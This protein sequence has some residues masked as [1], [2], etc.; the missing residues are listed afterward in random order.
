MPT[1]FR[2][3]TLGALARLFGLD[4]VQPGTH[5]L[6][7]L[8]QRRWRA[9]LSAASAV[10]PERRPRQRDPAQ[11]GVVDFDQ[12]ALGSGLLPLIGLVDPANLA[13]RDPS[14][15]QP[16]DPLLRR[17]PGKGRLDLCD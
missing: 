12:E 5:T 15:L 8:A 2:S 3:G 9:V 6:V 14:L 7:V 17:P 10:E 4:L 13:G 1:N 11:S 16:G